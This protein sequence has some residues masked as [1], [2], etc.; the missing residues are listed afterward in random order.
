MRNFLIGYA[1]ALAAVP[2]IV[3]TPVLGGTYAY[4]VNTVIALLFG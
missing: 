3:V 4:Y 1:V 2:F